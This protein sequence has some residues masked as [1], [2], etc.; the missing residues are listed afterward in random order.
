MDLKLYY[1][2]I[3]ETEAALSQPDVVVVSQET[4]DGGK[5][6]VLTEVPRRMA[7]KLVVEGKARPAGP[8]E[9]KQYYA[10]AEQR[11]KWARERAAAGRIR[12]AV[13]PEA[14]VR[15]RKPARKDANPAA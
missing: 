11:V 6:G 9:A 3:R 1:Q 5:A 4:P 8:E 7:A 10:D 2:R 13:I 14:D 15:P 12:V